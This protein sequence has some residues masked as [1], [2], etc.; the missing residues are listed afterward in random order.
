MQK[1]M[2]AGLITLML[3]SMAG[4]AGRG[5]WDTA[6]G[7]QSGSGVDFNLRLIAAAIAKKQRANR[8][9][10]TNQAP[11]RRARDALLPHRHSF[12]SM[13]STPSPEKRF[14]RR[15]TTP[16]ASWLA[17]QHRGRR[18]RGRA[19]SRARASLSAS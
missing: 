12:C 11:E 8:E 10:E 13:R 17:C 15:D 2:T 9:P 6:F 7:D 1:L 18:P 5:Q 19:R 14:S 4:S 3:L 16:I